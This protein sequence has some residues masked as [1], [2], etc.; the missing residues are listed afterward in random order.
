[1][2]VPAF[3]YKR[4][5]NTIRAEILKIYE[6]VLDS[7]MLILGPKVVLFEKNFSKYIGMKYGIGVNSGTDAIKIAFRSL[8]I[9]SGDEV[10]TVANTAVPTISAIRELGCIP[11]FV[12]IKPDFLIDEKL[13]ERYITKRT[14]AILPV[15]L[16]G[17]SCNMVEICKIAKNNN[18]F[19]IEDCAQADG[20]QLGRKMVGSFGDVS[21]F[22]FY[23]TKNLG[24]YGDGGIILVR[25]KKMYEQCRMLR[26]YGMKEKYYSFIEGYNSR[27]DEIQAGIL[28]VKLQYLDIWNKKRREIA[29]YYLKNINNKDI[30][31]PI[32]SSLEESV[33]HQF[34]I[35]VKNRNKFLKHLKRSNIGFGIHYPYPIFRQKAYK[36]LKNDLSFL[37]NTIKFSKE[38]VSIPIFPELNK[39]EI[40]YIVKCLNEYQK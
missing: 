24:A 10:I 18:L 34:V 28:N 12:D 19:V 3:D 22:S 35:R 38:I 32:I 23:P 30:I 7:G 14:K 1:M 9:K 40:E 29:D 16:Y 33:F 20:G 11:V 37:K 25:N 4:Q 39:N 31:L 8:G 26:K 21:C 2:K 17:K 6:E 27:L 15:H 5:L 13:I 36:F